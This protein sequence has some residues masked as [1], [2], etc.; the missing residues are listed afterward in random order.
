MTWLARFKLLLWC[1]AADARALGCPRGEFCQV[2]GSLLRCSP[3]TVRHWLY[4]WRLWSDDPP[5]LYPGDRVHPGLTSEE[6]TGIYVFG[7]PLEWFK[8]DP[9]PP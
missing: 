3:R 9:E 4:W 1:L 5:P 7:K 6:S 2:V 8:P